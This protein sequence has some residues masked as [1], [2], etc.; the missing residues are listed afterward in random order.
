MSVEEMLE[1]IT[2]EYRAGNLWLS[3]WDVGFLADIRARLKRGETFSMRQ[4]AAL[5]KIIDKA[6]K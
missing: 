3:Q 2:R 5:Q 4:V 1:K 6:C